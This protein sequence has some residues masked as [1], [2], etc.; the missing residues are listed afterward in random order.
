MEGQANIKHLPVDLVSI[1][2]VN[3]EESIKALKYSSKKLSFNNIYL[4][5]DENITFEYETIKI[6]KLRSIKEYNNFILKLNDYINSDF[7]LIIQDDGHIVNPHLWDD[8]FLNYDY[9]GAPWPNNK[10]WRN[11]FSKL[12]KNISSNLIKNFSFNQVGNGGF[13]LRSKKFLQYSSEFSDT[14]GL[15]EDIF[16]CIYNY[17]KA[18]NNGINFAPFKVA[19]NFSYEINLRKILKFSEVKNKKYNFNNH[20]GWH[21]KRFKNYEDLLNLKNL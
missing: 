20:F 12:D 14:M 15:A 9:I 16:L 13:S 8:N 5:T 3:P 17:E 2:C 10:K 4:F 19:K 7:V 6:E 11:R 18:I 1:N 21:G